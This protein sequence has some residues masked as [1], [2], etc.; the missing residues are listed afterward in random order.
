MSSI[1]TLA[2]LANL[3]ILVIMVQQVYL[4]N[5]MHLMNLGKVSIS[6]QH[7]KIKTQHQ[8]KTMLA[9]GKSDLGLED[10]MVMLTLTIN[11]FPII[12]RFH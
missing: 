2:V 1:V 8:V 11:G 9:S 3:V 5:L 6:L 7:L 12:E 4:V 10:V